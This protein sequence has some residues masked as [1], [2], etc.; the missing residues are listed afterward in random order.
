MLPKRRVEQQNYS[1]SS[2]VPYSA[3]VT[4]SKLHSFWLLFTTGFFFEFISWHM[5]RCLRSTSS[6]PI[7]K[8]WQYSIYWTILRYFEDMRWK[9]ELILDSIELI[10]SLHFLGH[11]KMILCLAN[12]RWIRHA[13]CF[14]CLYNIFETLF[15]SV[16][17]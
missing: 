14:F 12:V 2:S 16:F 5:M 6:L 17:L 15:L 7:W 10:F 3:P 8:K 9:P 1:H 11:G 13:R 4:P